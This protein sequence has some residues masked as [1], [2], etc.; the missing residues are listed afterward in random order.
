MNMPEPTTKKTGLPVT[1]APAHLERGSPVNIAETPL[2]TG[3]PVNISETDLTKTHPRT[4]LPVTI[5]EAPLDFVFVGPHDG[6]TK[7]L[8][9]SKTLDLL[10]LGVTRIPSHLLAPQASATSNGDQ[11]D[12]SQRVPGLYANDPQATL[13]S[14]TTF[15]HA[16]DRPDG[17]EE[18]FTF[19]WIGRS[20]HADV[21]P[22]RDYFR[23]C[24]ISLHLATIRD[25]P[26]QLRWHLAPLLLLCAK[27]TKTT[28]DSGVREQAQPALLF[29][30]LLLRFRLMSILVFI[31]LCLLTSSLAIG[32]LSA[33]SRH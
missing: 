17:R 15:A 28:R 3:H 11:N 30:R 22:I 13:Y 6:E 19:A 4:S 20:P 24:V 12:H 18:P 14:V 7:V 25:D 33:L 29:E 16:T 2:E 27:W 23:N 9:Q 21:G 10:L 31:A 5:A 1:I 26:E 8:A 32:I